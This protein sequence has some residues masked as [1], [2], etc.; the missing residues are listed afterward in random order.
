MRDK[1]GQ[2]RRGDA[3]LLRFDVDVDLYAD[4]EDVPG[5]GVQ[6]ARDLRS[7]NGVHPLEVVGDVAGLVGLDGTD[8]VPDDVEVR[9][10]GDLGGR[11]LDV[12]LAELALSR[13]VCG[14]H[15][16]RVA[17][18]R[19]REQP[20]SGRRRGASA[21]CRRRQPG[22]NRFHALAVVHAAV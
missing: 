17:C 15:L 8:E 19:H 16:G 7:V 20:G 22:E 3:G 9:Q 14:S 10:R 1:G 13:G 18:L 2:F 11:F 5:G 4:V 6:T 12:V 21:I